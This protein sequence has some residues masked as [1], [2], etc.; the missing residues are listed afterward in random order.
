[1]SHPY[2]LWR[3]HMPF[4]ARVHSRVYRYAKNQAARHQAAQHPQIPA[5]ILCKWVVCQTL[6]PV[7]HP[8]AQGP[9]GACAHAMHYDTMTPLTSHTYSDNDH[10]ANA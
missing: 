9:S 8:D 6:R 3:F 10:S 4:L 1:M 2:R 7:K 5:Q